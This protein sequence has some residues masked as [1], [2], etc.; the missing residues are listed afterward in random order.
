MVE[1]FRQ[2]GFFGNLDLRDPTFAV[3]VAAE[4]LE[5]FGERLV[6]GDD[7][8][9]DRGLDIAHG[10]DRL[11]LAKWLLGVDLGADL[12]ELD[13]HEV[14]QRLDGERRDADSGD[15]GAALACDGDPFMRLGK[16]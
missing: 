16:Q 1:Q 15:L 12:R 4:H 10:L 6:D 8:A 14:G 7:L 3:R 2:A 13:E 9:G 5:S 11:D